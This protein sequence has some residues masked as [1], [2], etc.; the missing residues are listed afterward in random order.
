MS[1]LFVAVWPPDDVV[2][3]LEELHRKD[4]RGVRFVAPENWHLTLRFLGE[5]DE[6]PV[7]EALE[8]A[9]FVRTTVVLG[10]GVD[11][12]G[13]YRIAVPARGADQLAQEARRATGAFGHATEPRFVGHLTL[14]RLKK[15]AQM[16]RVLG[17]RVEASWVVDDVALVRSILRP[18]GARYETVERYRTAVAEPAAE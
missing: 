16:P 14:A 6:A 4:Q 15:Q 8:R 11:L 13:R 1:R 9:H 12:I 7:A 17:H 5:A 2:A 10:P 18:D 3:T